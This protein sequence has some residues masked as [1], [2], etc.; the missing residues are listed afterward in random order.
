[1]QIPFN[2]FCTLGQSNLSRKLREILFLA[3]GFT[4]INSNFCPLSITTSRGLPSAI[5]PWPSFSPKTNECL[6]ILIQYL[7]K[8]IQIFTLFAVLQTPIP[9]PLPNLPNCQN[10]QSIQIVV[11]D[12]CFA[13]FFVHS[14]GVDSAFG[15]FLH[16]GYFH[17]N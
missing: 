12:Y 11:D 16:F 13:H 1:M 3:A 5:L 17:Q 15:H 7:I 6:N 4:F 14:F 10:G 8:F 2:V 9:F